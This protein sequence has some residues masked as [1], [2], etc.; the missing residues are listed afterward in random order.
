MTE[1]PTLFDQ[2]PAPTQEPAPFDPHAIGEH[3]AAH[4]PEDPFAESAARARRI[5]E[6]RG[7]DL[8]GEQTGIPSDASPVVGPH[9]ARAI[10]RSKGP[11]R[12]P[13]IGDQVIEYSKERLSKGL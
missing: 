4:A 12:E 2:E 10:L 5:I 1:G 13:T 7:E 8:A 11:R 6:S 3:I 9:A